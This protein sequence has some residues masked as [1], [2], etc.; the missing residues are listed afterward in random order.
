MMISDVSLEK[1]RQKE[2]LVFV[3]I[4]VLFTIMLDFSLQ[5]FST[6]L[7]LWIFIIIFHVLVFA[8]NLHRIRH[9]NPRFK[10]GYIGIST[11]NILGFIFLGGLFFINSI[12]WN[13]AVIYSYNFGAL[14]SWSW[15]ILGVL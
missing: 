8:A 13:L 15:G 6:A 2:W 12:L 10:Y 14:P 5:I 11:L 3:T 9:G 4:N 1:M 7:V